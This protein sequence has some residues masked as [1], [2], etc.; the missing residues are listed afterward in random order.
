MKNK[1]LQMTLL[2]TMVLTGVLM[3]TPNVNNNTN[4]N[5]ANVN[6]EGI[7][8]I[9]TLKANGELPSSTCCNY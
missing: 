1:F 5:I 9:Q 8:T 4:T 6:A 3:T 7:N 2:G